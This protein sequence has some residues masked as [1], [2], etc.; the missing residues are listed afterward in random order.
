[1]PD[2]PRRRRQGGLPVTVPRR[3]MASAPFLDAVGGARRATVNG[4]AASPGGLPAWGRAT[5]GVVAHG[6]PT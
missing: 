3:A 5:F 2:R 1:V 6:L 4:A